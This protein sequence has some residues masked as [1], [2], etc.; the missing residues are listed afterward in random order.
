MG[1]KDFTELIA[2]Q[3]ANELK[4]FIYDLAKA[5]AVHADRRFR[6][7]SIE[8]RPICHSQHSRGVRQIRPQGVCELSQDRDRV[9]VRDQGQHPRRADARLLE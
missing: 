6:E 3:L 5:P 9:G 4:A 1:A 7:E 2:W 8:A